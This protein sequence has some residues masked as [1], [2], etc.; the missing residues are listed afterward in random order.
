MNSGNG[1]VC[2]WQWQMNNLVR[3]LK[4]GTRAFTRFRGGWVADNES[5][6]NG[7]LQFDMKRK[8]VTALQTE[9]CT[10]WN[11]DGDND[12]EKWLPCY[13]KRPNMKEKKK[14]NLITLN[15]RIASD[16]CSWSFTYTWF[17]LHVSHEVKITQKSYSSGLL[18]HLAILPV[19]YFVQGRNCFIFIF[20]VLFFH[21]LSR[22]LA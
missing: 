9:G 10:M 22:S 3:V 7:C 6:F 18:S 1:M 13:A 15:A 14:S 17:Y 12:D 20:R 2:E 8:S 16:S 21:Y 4:K 19:Q 5:C 11:K